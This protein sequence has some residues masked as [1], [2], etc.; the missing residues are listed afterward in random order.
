MNEKVNYWAISVFSS[1]TM[2]FNA[3]NFLV[4]ALSM[5]EIVTLIPPRYLPLQAAVVALVNMWLRQVTVRPV[6]M[7]RPGETQPVQVARI[8]PPSP[9]TVTD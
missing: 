9:P 4:A 3:A 5:T 7:I 8:D 1:R 6:A 2:W